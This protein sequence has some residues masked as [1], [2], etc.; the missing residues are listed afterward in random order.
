MIKCIGTYTRR[1]TLYF[2]IT[3]SGHS[4]KG[5]DVASYSR[6]CYNASLPT[7]STPYINQR[8]Q[9]ISTNP[10]PSQELANLTD[11]VKSTNTITGHELSMML[12]GMSVNRCDDLGVKKMLEV[13][14]DKLEMCEDEV[15]IKMCMTGLENIGS[16]SSESQRLLSLLAKRLCDVPTLSPLALADILY[17]MRNMR[18]EDAGVLSLVRE[19]DR[20]V[21]VCSNQMSTAV[22]VRCLQGLSGLSSVHSEVSRLVGAL[23]PRVMSSEV[24]MGP[25]DIAMSMSS[26]RRKDSG[27]KDTRLLLSAL[28]K[29]LRNN[30][31]AHFDAESL[32]MC[33]N[34][35]QSC[36]V[37]PP[38]EGILQ[39]LV[40]HIDLC[41]DF[42]GTDISRMMIGLQNMTS[43]S[44]AVN[45]ILY[46]LNK[47]I[48]SLERGSMS[49]E[50]A[51]MAL[52]G[53]KRMT[54]ESKAVVWTTYLTDLKSAKI[55]FMIRLYIWRSPVFSL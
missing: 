11:T 18:S 30:S 42:T 5:T 54:T 43:A 14:G 20:L 51:A 26:L 38:V 23:A 39:E 27:S 46:A 40:P 12:G 53:M 21:R 37:C 17:S 48:R 34:C 25:R 22:V 6:L 52:S 47:S 50:D 4:Y 29:K 1:Y 10:N 9:M 35:L 13:L 8:V 44:N 49:N 31:S 24:A 2:R 16:S 33:V 41:S 55:L 3:S 7:T 28:Q 45:D 36:S 32:V 15:N 19:L